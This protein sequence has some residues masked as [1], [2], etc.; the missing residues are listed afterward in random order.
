[1][2]LVIGGAS[3]GKREY[4]MSEYGFSPEDLADA[5]ISD[6]SANG[7]KSAISD[8]PVIYNLQDLAA[9][10]PGQYKM[11]VPE[12]VKKQVVICNEVGCGI[13]PL[14]AF[15]R[16]IRESTGRLC[17]ILAQKADRVIRI[18]CGI[19]SVIKG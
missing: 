4:V 15:E 2:I 10:N 11:L 12:L 17:I 3:S 5:V 7:D 16:E 18:V 13:V 14:S 1:M 19:P 9:Q 6:K 8:K